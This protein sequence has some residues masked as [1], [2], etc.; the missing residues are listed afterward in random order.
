MTYRRRTIDRELFAEQF[1]VLYDRCLQMSPLR[2]PKLAHIMWSLSFSLQDIVNSVYSQ[3]YA[4]NDPFT[5]V[6]TTMYNII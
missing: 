5:S 1:N 6:V 3:A 2:R 4:V